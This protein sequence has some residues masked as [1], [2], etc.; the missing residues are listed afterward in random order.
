MAALVLTTTDLPGMAVLRFIQQWFRQSLFDGGAPAGTLPAGENNPK[1]CPYGLYAEQISGTAFTAPRARNRRTRCYRIRPSVLHRPFQSVAA[2]PF[3]NDFKSMNNDPSQMRW[4][5]LPIPSR[6][7]DIYAGGLHRGHSTMSG[8][9]DPAAKGGLGIY[10]FAM[11]S[12]M[13]D[14]VDGYPAGSPS[15]ILVIPRGVKFSVDRGIGELGARGYVLETFEGHFLLPELGPIGSNGLANPRDFE[16]PF[17]G[18]LFSSAVDHSPFGVVALHGNMTPYKYDLRKFICINSV[19]KDHPDPSIYTVLTCPSAATPGVAVV[20][21]VVFPP[22]WMVAEGTF[23]PPWYHRNTMAEFMGM[24]WEKYDAKEGFLPGGSSLHPYM[25]A[26]GPDAATFV[27]ASDEKLLV[28]RLTEWS[29]PLPV[30]FDK[31]LAFMFETNSQPK[32]TVSATEGKHRDRGYLECWRHLPKNFTPYAPEKP[33]M[34][35][36]V[37]ECTVGLKLSSILDFLFLREGGCQE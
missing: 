28:N 4:L 14:K 23:R 3:E 15:A 37:G 1:R 13:G 11:N 24:V 21:F 35:F 2:D 20:D 33:F 17:G 8:V 10:L 7:Q 18:K 29:R 9:G 32:L 12:D 22:R 36:E 5:P 30:K 19:S 26:H 16:S 34:A 25:S 6:Q 27:G 31:G